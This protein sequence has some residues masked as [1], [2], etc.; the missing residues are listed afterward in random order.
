MKT[1][2]LTF[3]KTRALRQDAAALP[4]LVRHLADKRNR[5][6]GSLRIPVIPANRALLREL[7]AAELAAWERVIGSHQ[8]SDQRFVE[9][10]P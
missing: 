1:E 8:V 3:G 10:T 2:L 5:L 9:V 6:S 4:F 7:R